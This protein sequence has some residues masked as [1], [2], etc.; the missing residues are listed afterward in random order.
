MRLYS[1]LLLTLALLSA[2]S[3]TALADTP[4]T[5]Y[6]LTAVN[7]EDNSKRSLRAIETTEDGADDGDEEDEEEIIFGLSKLLEELHLA[8]MRR[9]VRKEIKAADKIKAAE[10]AVAKKLAIQKE[11]ETRLINGWMAETKNP[12]EVYKALGLEKLGR[13]AKESINYPIYLRYEEKYRLTMRAR[14]N[15]IKGTVYA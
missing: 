12:N 1:I 13:K 11:T 3:S 10:S 7:N 14:M 8:K 2:A 5:A 9:S 15:R 6:S 4:A